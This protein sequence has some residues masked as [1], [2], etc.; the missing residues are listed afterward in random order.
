M[1]AADQSMYIIDFMHLENCGI[2]P[3]TDR[4][5]ARHAH[6]TYEFHYV[7]SGRG[8]F[9]MGGRQVAIRR[10]DF[11]YTRPR[12][13]H[14]AI[15]PAEG[16]YLLQYV[17]FLALEAG[18]DAELAQDLERGLTEGIP[19]RLG[20]QH[21]GFF[22]D[23]S[24]LCEVGDRSHQRA[25]AFKLAG[26]IYELISG[27]TTSHHGHPAVARALELMRSRV[28]EAYD[29]NDLVAQLGLE[30][31]YFIRLFK[32]NVGVSPMKYAMNLKMSV[33]AD[34]LR[35]THDPLTTV[36]TQVGFSDPY[37]FAKRFKQW[38]GSPPGAYRREG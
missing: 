6:D 9:E 1:V 23:L 12:T 33:A 13:E 30:K 10:G 29:L 16:D 24:R 34:L 35:T 31:S 27:T 28:G 14:R 17:A 25:A 8:S 15:V 36:A 37:H 38:S 22:A 20:D 26:L 11:F 5:F 3:R 19:R 32:R 21:H 18:R 4:S 7:V 2:L